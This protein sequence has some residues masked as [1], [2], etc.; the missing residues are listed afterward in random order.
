MKTCT[1]CKVEK[2]LDEYYKDKRATDGRVSKCKVCVK[3]W[4]SN[5]YINNK[6][7]IKEKIKHYVDNNKEEVYKRTNRWRNDNRDKVNKRRREIRDPQKDKDYRENNKE[8]EQA[9]DKKYRESEIGKLNKRISCSK[10]RGILKSSSD[11]TATNEALKEL[12]IKQ[13]NKCFHCGCELDH[14]TPY[15]VHIDHYQPLS[16]G[17]QHTLDNLVWSCGKCNWSKGSKIL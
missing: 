2:P 4:H 7:K 8:K 3:K 14:N 9:R 1:V 13:E 5:N 6:E 17:G 16:K 15:Q 12:L 11:G 10:R